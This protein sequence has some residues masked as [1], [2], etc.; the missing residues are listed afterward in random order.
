M[1]NCLCL[2]W[3]RNDG[4]VACHQ[5]GLAFLY[6]TVSNGPRTRPIWL[7][8]LLCTGSETRLIDCVHDGFNWDNQ[9]YY[10]DAGVFCSCKYQIV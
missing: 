8:N 9:C 3:S 4:I 1:G 10:K 5:L 7:D 2:S 6:T